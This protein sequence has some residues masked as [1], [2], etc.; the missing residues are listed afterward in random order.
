MS[1]MRLLN[2][3]VSR[4][5]FL[6]SVAYARKGHN[7]SKL[8]EWVFRT[9]PVTDLQMCTY[10]SAIR[11]HSIHCLSPNHGYLYVITRLPQTMLNWQNTTHKQV[12]LLWEHGNGLNQAY[13]SDKLTSNV[14]SLLF[15]ALPL[16]PKVH[17]NALC[18]SLAYYMHCITVITLPLQ[19]R[20]LP[21]AVPSHGGVSLLKAPVASPS[22]HWPSDCSGCF[23]Q[24]YWNGQHSSTLQL[25]QLFQ[26]LWLLL[27]CGQRDYF[28]FLPKSS[29]STHKAMWIWTKMWQSA[30]S[31]WQTNEKKLSNCPPKDCV[32]G[33]EQF[34]Q[35]EHLS[36][37]CSICARVA[38]SS[39]ARA[40]SA[41]FCA[42]KLRDAVK[43]QQTRMLAATF[44]TSNIAAHANHTDLR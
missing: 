35:F 17:W 7:W 37:A 25:L 32:I 9:A 42:L 10:V 4:W 43:S 3:E 21:H 24:N 29:D 39:S 22:I 28:D 20:E 13:W 8:L 6:Y 16:L 40:S 31:R 18:L 2:K 26:Q 11:E 12:Y 1:C 14:F 44:H 30:L 41:K 36:L 38:L 15:L 33:F 23:S 27:G 19:P 5:E 34:K